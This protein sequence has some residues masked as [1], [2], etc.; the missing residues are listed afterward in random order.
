MN[1]K[2]FER[3]LKWMERELRALK[4]D[5]E[6][7][8]GVFDFYRESL[9]YTAEALPP[10][11]LPLRYFYVAVTV[12]DGEPTPPFV[13][14]SVDP[15]L[16]EP[17]KVVSSNGGKTLT[18]T[19]LDNYPLIEITYRIVAISGSKIASIAITEGDTE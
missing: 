3:D 16:R 1:E 14:L 8:L 4:T 15:R 18:Y 13:Q 12:A 17:L 9:S 19:F 7:G 5:H 2:A 10:S 11:V 6:R